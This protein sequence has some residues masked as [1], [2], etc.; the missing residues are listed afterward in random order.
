MGIVGLDYP[1]VWAMAERLEIEVGACMMGKI[2]AL[3]NFV[4]SELAKKDK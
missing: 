3:E 1:A 2:Q 4:L